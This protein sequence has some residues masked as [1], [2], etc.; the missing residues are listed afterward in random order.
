MV[1]PELLEYH[2][3]SYTWQLNGPQRSNEGQDFGP[4]FCQEYDYYS[5]GMV[6]LEIALWMPLKEITEKIGGSPEELRSRILKE[7]VRVVRA[8]MGDIYANVLIS[9]LNIHTDKAQAVV[10]VQTQ[11]YE[12]MAH[13]LQRCLV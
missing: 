8:Y 7:F 11:F 10:D 13:P 5:V 12:R 3:P 2:H 9:C 4:Q 1:D 6:L